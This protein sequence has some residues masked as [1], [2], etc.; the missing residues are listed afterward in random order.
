MTDGRSFWSNERD[1]E[2]IEKRKAFDDKLNGVLRT[3]DSLTQSR[4]E[5]VFTTAYRASRSEF[6]DAK[7][8]LDWMWQ[9]IGSS[10][11]HDGIEVDRGDIEFLCKLISSCQELADLA[12]EK[13]RTDFRR[14][15]PR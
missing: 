3:W 15:N 13:Y 5:S 6:K 11:E 4:R 2:L 10:R 1:F 14:N 9:M 8:W 12:C 7:S